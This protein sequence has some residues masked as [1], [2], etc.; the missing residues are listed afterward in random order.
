MNLHDIYEYTHEQGLCFETLSF[1][2]CFPFSFFLFSPWTPLPPGVAGADEIVEPGS[3]YHKVWTAQPGRGL[4]KCRCTP[5][6]CFQPNG[7]QSYIAV[8]FWRQQKRITEDKLQA[9]HADIDA[10]FQQNAWAETELSVAWVDKTLKQVVEIES[11]FILF[12]DNLTAQIRENFTTNPVHTGHKLNV[13]YMFSLHP[14][15]M[16]LYL[17]LVVLFDLVSRMLQICGNLLTDAL[18]N[19][20]KLLLCSNAL[21]G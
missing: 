21:N 8:I 5:Q 9:W 13:L 18:Q 11:R 14:V 4:D 12:C 3:C 7:E 20:R 10:D 17:L 2:L 15:S 16:R 6:I 19:Y 1:P